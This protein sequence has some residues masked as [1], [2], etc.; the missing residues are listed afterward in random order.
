MNHGKAPVWR[1]PTH[2][3]Q[4]G[5]LH[6]IFRLHIKYIVIIGIRGLSHFGSTIDRAVFHGEFITE[7]AMD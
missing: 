4:Q 5:Q 2:L 3:I 6:K 1:D 7:F